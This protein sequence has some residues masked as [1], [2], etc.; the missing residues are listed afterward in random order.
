MFRN[1]IHDQFRWNCTGIIRWDHILQGLSSQ[2]NVNR[3]ILQIRKSD[4][5]IQRSFK[6]TDIGFNIIGNVLHNF[7]RNMIF[8]KSVEFFFLTK[9][10]HSCLIVRRGDVSNQTPLKTCAKSGFQCLNV[11]RRLITG[12]DNLFSWH[13]KVVKCME[14]FFLCTF[15]S[16]NK[17]NIVDQKNVIITI[18]LAEC[19][20]CQFISVLTYFKSIDQF[21]RKSFTCD[22]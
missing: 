2:R 10:R 1:H 18:F 9:N 6:L 8:L 5:F 12:D 14:K 15:F 11:L 4:Q 20:H 21:I 3:F 7:I 19:G 22:I 13:M 16:Y 17:L